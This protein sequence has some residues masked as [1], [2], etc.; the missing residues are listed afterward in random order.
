MQNLTLTPAWSFRSMFERRMGLSRAPLTDPVRALPFPQL[1]S[2]RWS[3]SL[4]TAWKPAGDRG[5]FTA[6]VEM[7][8]GDARSGWR[9]AAGADAPLGANAALLARSDWMSDTYAGGAGQRLVSHVDRSVLGV[10]F[11][12]ASFDALNAL[13]KLEWRRTRHPLGVTSLGIQGESERLIAIL[14]GVWLPD[15][16]TEIAARYGLRWTAPSAAT[17]EPPAVSTRA[18]FAGTRA[19]RQVWRTVRARIDGRLLV[20]TTSASV[21]WG[22]TPSLVWRVGSTLAIEGGYRA[23]PLTDSDFTAVGTP[24]LFVTFGVQVTES[25]VL[26]PVTFWRNRLTTER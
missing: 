20:E 23:G 26:H 3:L 6:D 19:E 4:G 18:H 21:T 9:V 16:A 12:P 8:D 14:E 17:A 7:H 15:G 22:L 10:A 5:R 25:A 13:A 2:N 1:E 24:G 11:R